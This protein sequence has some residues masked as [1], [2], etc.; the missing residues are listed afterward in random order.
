M[1]CNVERAWRLNFMC[2]VQLQEQAGSCINFRWIQLVF[3]ADL[4][5]SDISLLRFLAL[6]NRQIQLPPSKPLRYRLPDLRQVCQLHLSEGSVM[7]KWFLFKVSW[8]ML[9]LLL[10]LLKSLDHPA[11]LNS[12]YSRNRKIKCNLLCTHSRKYIKSFG[13]EQILLKRSE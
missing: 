4:S 13:C 12:Y 9:L 2:Q 11:I 5:V 10:L 1:F 6:G 8:L 3:L 7:A